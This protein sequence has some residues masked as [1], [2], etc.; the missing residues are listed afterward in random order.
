MKKAI[1]I[2]A[3][4]LVGSKLLELLSNDDK[5]GLVFSIS[6]NLPDNLPSN[7]AH[8]PFD[9]GNYDIPPGCN[10][11]Y[12]CLGTTM[13]KAGSKE[14]FLKV[15]L[16]MVVTFANKAKEAGIKRMAI[17]SSIG[18]NQRASNFYL[19]TKGQMEEKLK[20]MG[21][22]R[23]VIVRPS[24]LLG[25]RNETR[26]AEDFGKVIFSILGFLM[27]GPF[28]KYRG[29]QAHDVAIAMVALLEKDSDV[30]VI[31]SDKLKLI[32]SE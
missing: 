18:A 32:S 27:V 16:E 6:R 13:K 21:F 30:E 4:G 14:A 29:I 8:I 10:E 24:L 31:E 20:T 26:P 2:G 1:I 17:V 9:N 22:S 25:K 15:D 3:T 28:K 19:K 11:A 5:Y 7:A 23:L 12:C